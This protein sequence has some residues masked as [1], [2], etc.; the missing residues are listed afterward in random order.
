MNHI[1]LIILNIYTVGDVMLSLRD[2]KLS[3]DG[4]QV[5]DDIHLEVKKGEVIT[6]VG[7]VAPGKPAC[8]GA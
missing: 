1:I 6:L 5:L 2:L 7:P 3:F 8:C 4:N